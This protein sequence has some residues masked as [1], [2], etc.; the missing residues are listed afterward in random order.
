MIDPTEP[1]RFVWDKNRSKIRKMVEEFSK[2]TEPAK[3]ISDKVEYDPVGPSWTP[4][5]AKVRK[6][7]KEYTKDSI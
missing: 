1:P 7:I 6:M 3:P 5:K 2:E 4:D